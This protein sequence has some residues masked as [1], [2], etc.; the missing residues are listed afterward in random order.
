MSKCWACERGIPMSK[1]EPG[2]H[3]DPGV[4]WAYYYKCQSA[5]GHAPNHASSTGISHPDEASSAGGGPQESGKP[6]KE[7][8]G[9]RVEGV[10]P[11]NEDIEFDADVEGNL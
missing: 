3:E 11:S 9:S 1:T 10:S 8:L 4:A 6:A 5:H 2:I 7:A